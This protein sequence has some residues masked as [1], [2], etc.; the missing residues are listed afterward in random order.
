MKKQQERIQ[1]EA[2]RRMKSVV[3]D[4]TKFSK[5]FPQLAEE[6]TLEENVKIEEAMKNIVN[7]EKTM[8][9][10]K[11]ESRE[12]EILFLGNKLSDPESNLSKMDG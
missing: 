7:W 3:E 11:K 10:L 8:S 9:R 1:T 2:E 6:W 12:V 5:K 4:A